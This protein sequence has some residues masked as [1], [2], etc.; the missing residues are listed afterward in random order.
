LQIPDWR[1]GGR[2]LDEDNY[3]KIISLLRDVPKGLTIEEIARAANLSRTTATK[4]LNSLFVSGQLNMRKTGPAKIYSLSARLPADQ[5]LSKSSDPVIILDESYTVQEASESF[6][7]IFGIAIEDLT[8]RDIASTALG[9]GLIERIRDPLKQALAGDES[10]VDAWVPIRKEWKAFRVHVVPLVFGWGAKGVVVRLE[11]QTGEIMAREENSFLADL[12]NDSPVSVT[13][14]DFQG[15][16]LYSN[17]MNLELHGYS[18]AE[19]LR[20]NISDL[21]IPDS[22]KG[23]AERMQKL[24]EKGELTFEVSHIH[25]DGHQIP[26][27]VHAKVTT[28]GDRDVIVCIATDI[29]ERKRAE[30]VIR[31]NE[32]K[33]RTIFEHS[34]YPIAINSVPDQKFLAVNPAFLK[35]SGY[36][37]EELLGKNPVEAGILP[38]A[39]C[40]KLVARTVLAG[41][42][43][44][45]PLSLKSKDGRRIHIIFSSIPVTIGGHSACLTITAEVTRLK[46]IEEELLKKTEDLDAAY[47]ELTA[48]DEELR[49][50]YD[51]LRKNEQVLRESEET[52]RALVEQSGEGIVIADFSGN[53]RFTN[54]RALEIAEC[55]PELHMAETFNIFDI[56]SQDFQ[57]NAIHDFQQVL[58]GIDGYEV[59]YKILTLE[60]NEKWIAC[61]GKRISFK[62]SP[63]MLLSFRDVTAR[64]QEEE[65]LR[66]SEQKF[67]TLFENNPVPLTLVSADTGVFVDVN[68]AFL[69]GTGFS[70]PE[71]IG[72]TATELGLFAD[73][74]AYAEMVAWLRKEK[75]LKG[76]EMQCRLKNGAIQTCLFSSRMILMAGRPHIISTIEN[77]SER[78]AAD[79]AFQTMVSSML[80]TSGRESLDRITANLATWLRADC[81]MIGRILPDQEHVEVLSMILDG[82][83]ITGY[84]Y[85]LK[86]TPCEDAAKKG[87][88]LYTDNAAKAFPGSRDLQMLR[89]RGYAGTPLRNYDGT[90]VGIICIM[91]REPLVLPPSARQIIDI[92]AVKAAAEIGFVSSRN[93]VRQRRQ[94]HKSR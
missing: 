10:V 39:E 56:V 85:I 83:R 50:N 47:K 2:S 15:N 25:K 53:V 87:F 82:E 94:R 16:F 27:E 23:I 44:N 72:R 49:H 37:E 86:G 6:L 66:E 33:F 1:C 59:Y 70:R 73:S 13:V 57:E 69:N 30:T 81:V 38:L 68:D 42:L 7:R 75:R 63:A 48:V 29:T 67:S 43:E 21:D 80:G 45:V 55:P 46:R 14:L 22:R 76:M 9:P 34:P 4:Y 84:S 17:K 51:L 18:A 40:T 28:W 61:I 5:V 52:F 12:L 36:T 71:V 35:V 90:V 20:L 88:C 62:G 93:I 77:I 19:L 41:T 79:L 78:K 54:R 60:Q 58:H 8:G 65:Q 64:M 74:E 3:R 89:I 31:E 26:L 92:I 11:D 32:D 24:S 91:T